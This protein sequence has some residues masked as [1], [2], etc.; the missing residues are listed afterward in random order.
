MPYVM[1]KEP[2][3][4]SNCTGQAEVARSQP[5]FRSEKNMFMMFS[6]DTTA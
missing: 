5:H 4:D 1:G 6:N 2:E 3:N